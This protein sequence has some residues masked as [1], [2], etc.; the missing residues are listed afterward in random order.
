MPF[1]FLFHPGFLPFGPRMLC[2]P[3]L[4]CSSR[5]LD[6]NSFSHMLHLKGFSPVWYISC[7]FRYFSVFSFLG[8][9][10]HWNWAFSWVSSCSCR[11][12]IQ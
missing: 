12:K 1:S 7:S 9:N 8:Q 5:C 6:T 11:G 10:R 4:C 3:T 2:V